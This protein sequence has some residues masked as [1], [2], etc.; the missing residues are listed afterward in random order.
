M[1]ALHYAGILPP[2]ALV[3]LNPTPVA[4]PAPI[5]LTA[6]P[7]DLE[8]APQDASRAIAWRAR[9]TPSCVAHAVAA[10]PSG[11]TWRHGALRFE[12][13]VNGGLL[14]ADALADAAC[15]TLGLIF[16]AGLPEAR[17][18]LALQP[19]GAEGSLFLDA[20]GSE[21]R[22]GQRGGETQLL[23]HETGAAD[24]VMLVL[25]ALGD[26][27]AW[28]AANGGAAVRAGTS[29]ATVGPADLFIACR[30]ARGG[31]RNKLGA[32]A[33]S[34]VLIWP[35]QNLLAQAQDVA[36]SGAISLWQERT[37]HGL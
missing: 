10:N 22:L 30:G 37:R 1:S 3:R 7:D 20:K 35:G 25:L 4:A 28:L 2:G 8:F 16:Q 13:E 5:W 19:R 33:L 27:Q 34:D 12:A 32:F 23:L 29:L 17:T 24:Q 31:L 14:L 18:L 11:T 26:G 36:L 9:A 15:L 6:D 21:L